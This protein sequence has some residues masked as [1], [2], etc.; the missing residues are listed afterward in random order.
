MTVT[1]I[2]A[3]VVLGACG[4]L[5]LGVVVFLVKELISDWLFKKD[6]KKYLQWKFE[7]E[8]PLIYKAFFGGGNL[9]IGVGGSTGRIENDPAKNLL[10]MSEAEDNSGGKNV[11]GEFRESGE[12]DSSE[13]G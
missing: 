7:A 6:L 2:I 11:C 5:V 3:I 10:S 12:D 8:N 13:N 4:L 1:D 9:R